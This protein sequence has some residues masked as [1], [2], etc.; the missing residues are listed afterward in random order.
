M[1]HFEF[2]KAVANGET[3]DEIKAYAKAQYD[4]EAEEREAKAKENAEYNEK[5]MSIID[6]KKTVIASEVATALEVHTS[7]ANYLLKTLSDSGVL[8]GEY[9]ST[10]KGRPVKVYRKA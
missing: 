2:I 7:K 5:I 3:T 6:E 4:K 10:A 1:T 9:P 8:I